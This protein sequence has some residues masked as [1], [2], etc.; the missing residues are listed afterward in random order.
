MIT[1]SS[2][3]AWLSW[4]VGTPVV[5]ISGFT[6]PSNEFQ[7]NNIR[8]HNDSVCNSCWNDKNV[9]FDASDWMYCPRKNDF[10]C[11]KVIQPKDVIDGVK[12]LMK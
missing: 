11:S 1:I 8:I 7:S 10:V 4:A 2:G 5:M 6:K 3:L 12:K 9:T